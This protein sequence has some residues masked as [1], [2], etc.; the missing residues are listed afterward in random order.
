MDVAIKQWEATTTTHRDTL[1]ATGTTPEGRA[2]YQKLFQGHLDK[3]WYECKDTPAYW[4]ALRRYIAAAVWRKVNSHYR[5]DATLKP[6]VDSQGNTIDNTGVDSYALTGYD[7]RPQPEDVEDIVQDIL[8]WIVEHEAETLE[9]LEARKAIPGADVTGR[10]IAKYLAQRAVWLHW[11]RQGKRQKQGLLSPDFWHIVPDTRP[12]NEFSAILRH[13]TLQEIAGDNTKL[14]ALLEYI[15]DGTGH[16]EACEALGIHRK[17]GR[18]W[19]NAL[20][21]QLVTA[22]PMTKAPVGTG[23][24]D[25]IDFIV[26]CQWLLPVDTE[27]PGAYVSRV[28]GQTVIRCRS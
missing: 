9:A 11:D 10:D 8:C 5:T 7:H 12:E 28:D 15:S 6:D 16:G 3:P 25:F 22:L 4:Q 23:L 18:R 26:N 20:A 2:L 14:L 27:C 17:T 21:T 24:I 1:P 19:L 13:L